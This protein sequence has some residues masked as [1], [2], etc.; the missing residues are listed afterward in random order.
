MRTKIILIISNIIFLLALLITISKCNT[1]KSAL[2]DCEESKG[3]MVSRQKYNEEKALDSNIISMQK[4]NFYRKKSEL[5]DKIDSLKSVKDITHQV[6][7]RTKTEYK[8]KV[9]RD[10]V[11][12]DSCGGLQ[13]PFDLKDYSKWYKLKYRIEPEGITRERLEFTN[14]YTVTFGLQ[15]HGIFY[16]NWFKKNSPVVTVQ[17]K[18]PNTTA[19]N[20]KNYIFKDYKE[21]K[22][23]IS[24]GIGYGVGTNGFQPIIGVFAGYNIAN[25]R[26]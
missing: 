6:K 22:L 12:T 15:D 2:E 20:T 19:K 25:I 17:S 21:P 3:N 14:D 26:I 24:V 16:K 18:N 1:F 10:T 5:Q 11:K 8:T 23:N 13:L 9:I 7:Y 4:Q